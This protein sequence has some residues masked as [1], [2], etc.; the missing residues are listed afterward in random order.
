M[1]IISSVKEKWNS[2]KTGE[3]NPKKKLLQFFEENRRKKIDGK[4]ID[5]FKRVRLMLF[6]RW[7]LTVESRFTS[8]DLSLFIEHMLLEKAEIDGNKLLGACSRRVDIF[9]E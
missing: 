9:L 7:S 8:F 5:I 2:R 3:E 1:L 4:K 6:F